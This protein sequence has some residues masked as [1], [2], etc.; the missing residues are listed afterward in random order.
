V[1]ELPE[2]ETMVRGIRPFVVNRQIRAVR[3][4]PTHCK[5]IQLSPSWKRFSAALTGETVQH[6]SRQGKRVVLK[7]HSGTM[8]AIEPRMTGLVLVSDP[9][10]TAHLRLEWELSA[11]DGPP[12]HLWFWDRRGLGTVQLIRSE[13]VAEAVRQWKLG[14]D[15]LTMTLDDWKALLARTSR[16][17]K[18]LLLDQSRVAGIGNLY[19]S[20]ILHVARLHPERRSNSLKADE[21]QRLH[22]AVL[23]VLLQAIED[24]GST[25]GDG[26]YRNALNQAGRYQNHHRVYAKAGERCTTCHQSDI[27]RVVQAQRSTFFCPTCQPDAR[28]RLPAR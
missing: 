3:K 25:L 8:V 4:C 21:T 5:P 22:A 23:G 14:P 26:T 27:V 10:D 6:V 18:V 7:M 24:E 1:P 9:P 13:E 20:E 2:V 12:I 16:P 11:S 28:S 15:A 19:A 17:L